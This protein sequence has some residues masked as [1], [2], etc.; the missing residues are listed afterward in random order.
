VRT[1]EKDEGI[2]AY[3]L[4]QPQLV[5]E[6]KTRTKD[7]VP[8]TNDRVSRTKDRVPRIKGRVPRID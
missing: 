8:R 5:E 4:P 6:R 2:M 7:R 1:D 3:S